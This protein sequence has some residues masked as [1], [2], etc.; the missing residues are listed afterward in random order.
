V[1]W[2][3]HIYKGKNRTSSAAILLTRRQLIS[4]TKPKW[5]HSTSCFASSKKTE[6]KKIDMQM[7]GK[8]NCFFT[9]WSSW[10]IAEYQASRMIHGGKVTHCTRSFSLSKSTVRLDGVCV[11]RS[12]GSRHIG[13][14][15]PIGSHKKSWFRLP[16]GES[17]A[18]LPF[19]F[20]SPCRHRHKQ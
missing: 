10:R 8:C 14:F 18:A 1:T 4:R 7:Y 15:V 17:G 16:T 12:K 5:G 13:P 20:I 11:H 9:R 2:I 19:L 6:K 3:N